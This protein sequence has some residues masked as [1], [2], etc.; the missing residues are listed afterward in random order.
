ML[1]FYGVHLD[2]WP[3]DLQFPKLSG[4]SLD[5][6]MEIYRRFTGGTLPN[7]ALVWEI[8]EDEERF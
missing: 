3:M 6:A 1:T 7:S 4:I 2:G 8:V 5:E